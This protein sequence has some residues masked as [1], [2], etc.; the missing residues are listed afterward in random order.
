M[1]KYH[2]EVNQRP[3]YCEGLSLTPPPDGNLG[4]SK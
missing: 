3:L 4:G 1:P 2:P